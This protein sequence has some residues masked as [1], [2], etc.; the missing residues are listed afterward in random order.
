MA[1]P[2]LKSETYHCQGGINTKVSLYITADGEFLNLQNVDFRSVGALSSFAGSTI[3]TAVGATSN[4]TGIA[5]FYVESFKYTTFFSASYAIIATDA[6]N[7]NAVT[8]N[9]FGPVQMPLVQ[10]GNTF[11]FSFALGG[12]ALFG[13]NGAGDYWTFQGSTVFWQA[14]LPKPKVTGNQQNAGSGTGG[15]S[16]TLVLYYSLVRSDG[17]FGPSLGQTYTVAG[18]TA[19]SFR[20]PASVNTSI[21][22]SGLSFGSFGLSGIQ[23]WAS[24]NGALPLGLTPLIGLTTGALNV[25]LPFNW[26][27]AGWA[28]T[29]PQP[30]D[31]QGSFLYG[32]GVTQG[33]DNGV[34]VVS[35]SNPAV[36]ETYASQLFATGFNSNPSRVVYSNAGTPEVNDYANFFDVGTDNLPVSAMRSYFSQMVLWKSRQTWSLSGTGPDTFVLTNVSTIYGCIA[37]NANVV[38]NQNCWF[39]DEKGIFEFNGANVQCVSNKI[40]DIFRRMNKTAAANTAY[41]AHEKGRNEVWCAI[42]IDG[43]PVNNIIVVFDYLSSAWTTRTVPPGNF[44]AVGAITI[45]TTGN[46]MRY[47]SSGMIGAFGSSYIG[48]NGAAFTSIIKT[49]FIEG[50]LGNSVT[51]MFRRLYVDSTIP[52]GQTYPVTVNFYQDKGASIVYSTTMMLSA[53]QNRIDFGI[54]AK[55][56]AV[57]FIYSG[58][59]F[60]QLSG[61]TIEYRYQRNT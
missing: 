14:G 20:M 36:I 34:Y 27:A 33:S 15:L 37:K 39:L 45:G 1:Y 11:P 43:S 44:T 35:T 42:P 30:Y 52:A 23:V 7:V 8:G 58:A 13:C 32:L 22:S 28:I 59:S 9:T 61:F 41:M 47:G 24:L 16:G 4:I 53:Y 60:F 21:G 18:G 12:T 10:Q 29:A 26:T 50:N 31:Y 55:S 48:D 40:D 17:L 46:L 38:W 19:Q 3:L 51:K 5:G 56:V 6:Y 57:E 2:P 25:T 54:P 49:R